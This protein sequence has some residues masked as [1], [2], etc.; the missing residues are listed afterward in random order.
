MAQGKPNE[1][2]AKLQVCM[3]D[4]T[5]DLIA[6]MMKAP[7][8]VQIVASPPG[9]GKTKT[10][11]D[12]CRQL[13]LHHKKIAVVCQTN[14]QADDFCRRLVKA[15]PFANAIRFVGGNAPTDPPCEGCLVIKSS[16]EFPEGTKIVVGTAAKWSMIDTCEEMDCMIVDEAWQ[17]TL[18]TFL[19]MLRFCNRFILIGDPGQIS[20]VVR[21]D[22]ERWETSR[23]AP[24]LAAPGVLTQNMKIQQ[25]KLPATWRLP[26]DTAKLIQPFYD[27][28]FDSAAQDGERSL[29]VEKVGSKVGYGDID[30]ALGSLSERS[31]AS[32]LVPAPT[33]GVVAQRDL[34]VAQICANVVVR[35]LER[36][37]TAIA[38]DGQ[39]PSPRR[40]LPKDIGVSS[41]HRVMVQAIIES[42]PPELRDVIHV[43]TPERWQG[44]ECELMVIAHPLSNVTKASEFDLETGR[45]CVMTSRHR[46]GLVVVSR[47]HVPEMLANILPTA[48]QALGQDD[49]FGLGLFRHRAFWDQLHAG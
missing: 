39:D 6:S 14:H 20:P 27:F 5:N 35:A 36:Q 29:L 3:S 15:C 13:R 1:H 21:N 9:A 37:G 12:V 25:R 31:V 30:A 7:G 22:T 16:K 44:L 24:H 19:P 8:S 34:D 41:T 32:V 11:I 26:H 10:I 17:M 47:D 45:L 28:Q 2:R 48:N 23:N 40:L 43:D 46:S 38:L 4:L 18:A 49:V 33:R 42:L